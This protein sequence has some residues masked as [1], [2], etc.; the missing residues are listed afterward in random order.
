MIK[1]S[2]SF[3][4]LILIISCKE[5]IPDPEQVM[6]IN[7]ENNNTCLFSN[8]NSNF[9]DVEFSWT[10][11]KHTD[12]YDLIIENQITNENKSKTTNLTTSQMSLERG[13]PY[14]WYVISKSESSENI[15]LSETRNFYLEAQSQLAHIPFPA[16]L[17]Y[18]LNGSILNSVNI[19][20]LQWEGYDLDGDIENYDL[21]IENASNGEEIKY[22][23]ILTQ[24]LEV[25]LQKGNV[26]L[27]KII[28]R[29]KENNISTSVTSNFELAN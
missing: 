29:D 27:W 4:I 5:S 12:N 10:E 23:K 9:A 15:A 21:I 22:E 3:F 14:S 1:K 26:Y 11:S 19:V 8:S 17:I 20:A 2:T 25:E 24:A 7:P 6:L 28:T 13:A 18:P 16:K